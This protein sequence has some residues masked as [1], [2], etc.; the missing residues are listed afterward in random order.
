MTVPMVDLKIQYEAIQEEINSA[1][2]GVIRS[3]HFIRRVRRL[4]RKSRLTTE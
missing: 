3:A 2:L 1:V 4:R